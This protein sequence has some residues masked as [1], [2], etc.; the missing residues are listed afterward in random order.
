MK[1][2][3]EFAI[4]N[5]EEQDGKL[6]DDLCEFIDKNAQKV[7]DFFE[8]K[9]KEKATINIIPTKAEYD[10]FYIKKYNL[11]A[12]QKV[13]KWA[14]GS[15]ADDGQ[16]YYVSL[17]DYKNTSHAYE[18]KDFEAAL[19]RYK[20]TCLHEFVHFVNLKYQQEKGCGR[21]ETWLS[22]GLAVYLSGQK[23]DKE[24]EG[25]PFTLQQLMPQEN[26]GSC[27][28]GWYMLI[29]YLVENYPKQKIF[30]LIESNR[31]AREFLKDELFERVR[32]YFNNLENK[33][34]TW[35]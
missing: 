30:E 9:K 16:I 7:Y 2:E 11:K 19:V 34:T 22:E 31:Q 8:I 6:I 29:K 15:R 27:Y 17:F 13:P 25:F 12:D 5:F 21:T 28:D 26:F 33:K 32:K 1:K 23:E 3:C 10:A 4:F 14:I 18:E 24:I 35:N 20:K